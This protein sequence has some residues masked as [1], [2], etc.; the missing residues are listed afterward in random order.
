MQSRSLFRSIEVL[1]QLCGILSEFYSLA[2]HLTMQSVAQSQGH[3]VRSLQSEASSGE[4]ATLQREAMEYDRRQI[5]RQLSEKLRERGLDPDV[6]IVNV[7]SEWDDEETVYDDTEFF[8]W[9]QRDA[10]VEA[11]TMGGQT[12][13]RMEGF[14]SLERALHS[15]Q[16]QIHY[17]HG[18]GSGWSKQSDAG[19]HLLSTQN[20]L[21]S[22]RQSTD[23]TSFHDLSQPS[24]HGSAEVFD[25]IAAS[26]DEVHQRHAVQTRK[27][28]WHIK[29]CSS[30]LVLIAIGTTLGLAYFIETLKVESFYAVAAAGDTGSGE[31]DW[32]EASDSQ[33]APERAP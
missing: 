24:D 16:H 17:G 18:S 33:P 30:L 12:E 10:A 4:R 1:L 2:Y 27:R 21:R 9:K 28:A 20:K 31:L 13:G 32:N 15:H 22:M 7:E 26:N 3:S 25:E 23:W 14:D 5:R 8:P 19:R 29:M 11:A 6:E